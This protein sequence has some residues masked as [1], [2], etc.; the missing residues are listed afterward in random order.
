MHAGRQVNRHIDRRLAGWM[1]R[2]AETKTGGEYINEIFSM[3]QTQGTEL[4]SQYVLVEGT[5]AGV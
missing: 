5:G 2:R 1:D 4:Q 3:K